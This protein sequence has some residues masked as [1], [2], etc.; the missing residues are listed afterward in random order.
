[1][2]DQEYEL[3]LTLTPTAL[4]E[5]AKSPLLATIAQ[6]PKSTMLRSVYFDTPDFSLR[7]KGLVLRIRHD[8]SRSVQTARMPPGRSSCRSGWRSRTTQPL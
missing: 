1:M 8:G 3:K 4:E 2:S 5:L 7:K 6:K